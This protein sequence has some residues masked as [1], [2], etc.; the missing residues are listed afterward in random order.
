MR[1]AQ[2]ERENPLPFLHV[3]GGML[4][5]GSLD[6]GFQEILYFL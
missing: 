4:L 2:R 1:I 5:P 6:S 3:F